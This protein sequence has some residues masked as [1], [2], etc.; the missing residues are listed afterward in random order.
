MRSSL[1]L[2]CLLVAIGLFGAESAATVHR[3]GSS[4]LVE[5]QVERLPSGS[6]PL[7]LWRDEDGDLWVAT[8]FYEWNIT[9]GD[10]ITV[11]DGGQRYDW[12]PDP[13]QEAS[14][15][16]VDALFLSPADG[17]PIAGR[18]VYDL[19]DEAVVYLERSAPDAEGLELAFRASDGIIRMTHRWRGKDAPVEVSQKPIALTMDRTSLQDLSGSFAAGRRT[20]ARSYRHAGRY[21]ADSGQGYSML[22]AEGQTP[23]PLPP[24]EPTCPSMPNPTSPSAYDPCRFPHFFLPGA[25]LGSRYLYL[26]GAQ[27]EA[28]LEP[29]EAVVAALQLEQPDLDALN[30]ARLPRYDYD[31]AKNLPAPGDQVTFEARVANYGGQATGEFAYTWYLDGT[32]VMSTSRPSLAPGE[33]ATLAI[34]W[35]WQPGNHTVSLELDPSNL[36]T[37]VS[38]QNNSV[39]DR[40]NALA[41]GFWVEQ[42]VYDYFNL[43]QV[44]LGLG[45]VSWDD[46]AQRQLRLWNQMMADAIHPLTPQGILDRVRLDKVTVVPDGTLPNPYP[47]NYPETS[48]HTVDL[49]WGFPSELVGVPSTHPQYGPLYLDYPAAC[50]FEPSLLHEM[51]HARYLIDLYGLN[52]GF[53]TTHLASAIDSTA[54]TVPVD[55]NVEDNYGWPVP[56]YLAVEGELIVCQAKGTYSFTPCTRGAEGTT[57][58]SH[59]EGAIVNLAAVRLQDGAGNLVMAG[60][61]MPL[62]SIYDDH[63][64]YNRYP[65]DL[66]NSG[67]VY[68]QYSAYA[69]NRIAGRRPICGNYNAPCNIGEYANDLPQH[70]ILTIRDDNEQPVP[71]AAVEVYQ[72]KPGTGWYAKLYL[73][74]PDAA[75]QTDAQGNV[76]LG[77]FPF[78]SAPPIVHTYGHSNALLL[79]KITH[80]SGPEYRFFEVTVPNETYWGMLGQVSDGTGA[81]FAPALVR[82]GMAELLSIWEQEGTLWTARSINWGATWSAATQLEGCCHYDPALAQLADDSLALVYRW[83]DDIWFRTST[84]GG[85]NWSSPVRVT[86]HPA[87]DQDPDIAPM[88]DG[89]LW[90]V[91]QSLRDGHDGIWYSRSTDGGSLWSPPAEI[92]NDADWQGDP[93]IV[94]ASDGTIWVVW[95]RAYGLAYSATANGG[96]DWTPPAFLD[97]GGPIGSPSIRRAVDGT[98]WLAYKVVY[99]MA[100][101]W[102]SHIYY[103]TST[104]NGSTWSGPQQYTYFVGDNSGPALA[105]MDTRMGL[106]WDSTRANNY[107]I[108]FGVF[109]EREDVSPPPF[110]SS[111]EREPTDPAPAELVTFRASAEDETA[112]SSVHLVWELNGAPQADVEM[113]DD[114]AHGDD[115]PGDGR[116]GVQLGPFAQGDEVS[117][118]VRAGDGD[119]NTYTHSPWETFRAIE[120]FVKTANLLFVPDRDGEST[121]WLRPYFSDT[122]D[123]LGYGYDVW[124][125][126][127]RG[128]PDSPTLNQYVDGVVIWAAPD[129]GLFRENDVQDDLAAYLDAG[130]R[131]FITGQD[132]GYYEGA[133]AFYQDYLHATYVQDNTGIWT[134]SGTGGDP[135]GDGLGL[136]ISGGDGADNQDWPDE[137]DPVSPAVTVLTYD[138]TALQA[139]DAEG[140]TR[141]ELS[142]RT[143]DDRRPSSR[144]GSAGTASPL[145]TASSGT[146]GLRVDTGTY[147]VVYFSFG[148]E[149]I[150]SAADRST[151]MERVLDWLSTDTASHSLVSDWTLLAPNVATDPPTDAQSAR[152][153]VAAQGGSALQLC[154]WLAD[155]QNWLCYDGDPPANNF[156]IELGQGYFLQLVRASTWQRTGDAP[157][158]PVPV[159]IRPTWTLM[160][161]PKL[162]GPMTAESLLDEATGQGGACS[163]L[164]RWQAGGWVG[165]IRNLPFNDFGLT[166]NE[167]Y[168]AR[169]A[170]PITYTPGAGT[171]QAQA[172]GWPAPV[173]PEALAP[174]DDPVLSDVLV[175]NLR[176]VALSITWRTD[177]PSTGW[178]EYAPC[179]DCQSYRA[180]DD[181]GE[182][183][184]SQVHHVTLTGLAPE[185]TYSFRVHSGYSVDD[186]DGALYQ[187]T[188]KETGMPPIP[189]LAYGQVET[190]D[191]TPEAG[192]PAVGA[193]V[194]MWL[195]DGDGKPSDP[196][197]TLVDGYGYWSLNLRSGTDLPTQNCDK[198]ALRL[199]VVGPMGSEAGWVQN[200]CDVLPASRIMLLGESTIRLYLPTI[201]RPSP[202]SYSR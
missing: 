142:G 72:A 95:F 107:D 68:E 115:G 4:P 59:G 181:L 94:Q 97:A 188:T 43:H 147:K 175:T 73:N 66:M 200:A 45:S 124:D 198:V 201:L 35:I 179:Q 3:V 47:S 144:A 127:L 114:G 87:L 100:D 159:D 191:G 92:P 1:V 99:L 164:Y 70:I 140:E 65:D 34:N 90:I 169:C 150:N 112:V 160:G 12:V 184:V 86:D 199:E 63:L 106:A 21:A 82:A 54:T 180:D 9:G 177:Q 8:S 67:V 202:K 5:A 146:A 176:D 30:I 23:G 62:V 7:R 149:A 11:F 69:W 42:S 56:T 126:G 91:W 79:L 158:S 165:H 118:T 129:Y 89:S 189:Y 6:D 133:S 134:L 49:M 20:G 163:E 38:E 93:S 75:Y 167:G 143:G 161:M 157:G 60:P 83:N 185:T 15:R 13:K 44:E 26:Y 172:A 24:D 102:R 145:G 81:D 10:R 190:V 162:P 19:S 77:S 48:D 98:L 41:V 52:L 178:V 84:D 148:F 104:D 122:L 50:N 130:G 17:V 57:P 76:D 28:P 85:L 170:N 125:T 192:V 96:Q 121:D 78:G 55:G 152:F 117:Y 186:N 182:G 58:R 53:S 39:E 103:Q 183:T 131:L 151:T 197:S 51:S 128:A 109:G 138:S 196:L 2:L 110:V 108:W 33:T 139:P 32:P 101:R 74:A 123:D 174:I 153:E 71:D 168:F 120:P 61:D 29:L 80:G 105:P 119:G 40:T 18:I 132:I 16:V 136:T 14:D 154:A 155:T 141:P 27:P 193:L 116:Y 166:N 156:P 37:E 31:A 194:R 46:W 64:Y 22:T 187:V 36:I 25:V 137:I 113:Y 135:I 173:E 171:S 111:V 195:V 88:A